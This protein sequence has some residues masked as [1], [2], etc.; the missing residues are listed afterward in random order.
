MK[1]IPVNIPDTTYPHRHYCMQ[2]NDAY[3]LHKEYT[4]TKGIGSGWVEVTCGGKRIEV[5]KK[6]YEKAG[7]HDLL[8]SNEI[9]TNEIDPKVFLLIGRSLDV[10]FR[11]SS[12]EEDLLV[13]E[14]KEKEEKEKEEKEAEEKEAKEKE[15]KE[16]AIQILQQKIK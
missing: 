13:K 10:N 7:R 9:D 16:K 5:E 2:F 14:E 11:Y 4:I 12:S 3:V 8:V 15:E 6:D 1:I